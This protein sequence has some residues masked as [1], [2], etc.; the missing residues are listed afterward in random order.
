MI[1]MEVLTPGVAVVAGLWSCCFPGSFTS[2]SDS[3]C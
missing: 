3:I 2:S 1:S